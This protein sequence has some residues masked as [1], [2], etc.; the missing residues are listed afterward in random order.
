MKIVTLPVQRVNV[1][2]PVNFLFAQIE[3]KQT[4]YSFFHCVL[5]LSLPNLFRPIIPIQLHLCNEYG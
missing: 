1:D 4:K 2:I 3:C 5:N